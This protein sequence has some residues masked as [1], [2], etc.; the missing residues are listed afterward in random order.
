M[1]QFYK[2]AHYSIVVGETLTNP[3]LVIS[4]DGIN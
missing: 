1:I 4:K 3:T 2:F